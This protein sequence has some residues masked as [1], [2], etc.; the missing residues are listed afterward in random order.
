MEPARINVLPKLNSLT[1][2]PKR[3]ARRPANKATVPATIKAIIIELIP[4]YAA[5]KVDCAFA[6]WP[7]RQIHTGIMVLLV[8]FQVHPSPPDTS[9][10][11]KQ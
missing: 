4:R 10:K 2:I 5:L 9:N 1:G 8:L 6:L 7:A 3:I 11:P